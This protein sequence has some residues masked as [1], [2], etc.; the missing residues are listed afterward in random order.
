M[1]E[2]QTF[3]GMAQS[4]QDENAYQSRQVYGCYRHGEIYANI[5]KIN[6]TT[7]VIFS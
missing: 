4:S 7:L 6:M 1:E 5:Y 2:A 3:L